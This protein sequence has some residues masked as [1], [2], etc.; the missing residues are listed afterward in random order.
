MGRV[1]HREGDGH[2]AE[3]VHGGA[4]HPDPARAGGRRQDGRRLPQVRHQQ[5][6]VLWKAKYG[7]L[8]VSDAKRLKSLEHENA[9]L[10]KLL[11]EAMLD[12]AVP[13]EIATKEW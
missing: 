8:E 10:K 9:K 12:N 11:A 6:H 3:P 1:H 4:G 13:K 5:R 2:E 7:G